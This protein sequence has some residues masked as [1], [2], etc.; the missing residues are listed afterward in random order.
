[1]THIVLAYTAMAYIGMAYIVM[2]CRQ[3]DAS[4]FGG[5]DTEPDTSTHGTANTSADRASHSA[6]YPTP[7]T[8]AHTPPFIEANPLA[9]PEPEPSTDDWAY[10]HSDAH[11][12]ARCCAYTIV[13][14]CA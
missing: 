1:M 9:D 2:A 11:A 7:D 5:T 14:A 3:P 13:R 10:G 6:H 8:G 4:P 12:N